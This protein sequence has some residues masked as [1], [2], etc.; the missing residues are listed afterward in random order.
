MKH[1]KQ[2]MN[3][4]GLLFHHAGNVRPA[5]GRM[6]KIVDYTALLFVTAMFAI[7]ASSS[8]AGSA[9]AEDPNGLY[10]HSHVTALWDNG[11][12]CGDHRCAPGEMPRNPTIVSPVKGIN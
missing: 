9:F 8:F 2:N 7:A 12:V 1:Q 10:S 5:G 3:T 11:L 6:A 4:D